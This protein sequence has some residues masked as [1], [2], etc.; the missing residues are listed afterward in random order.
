[1]TGSTMGWEVCCLFWER[2]HFR[3]MSYDD[4]GVGGRGISPNF[5]NRD[6]TIVI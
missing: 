2:A 3:D 5:P 4:G 6:N 1:M